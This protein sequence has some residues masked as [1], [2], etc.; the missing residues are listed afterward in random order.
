V[1][2]DRLDVEMI[3]QRLNT[4]NQKAQEPLE[5]HT[6]SATNAAQGNPFHQQAFDERTGVIRD[7]VLFEAVDKLTAAVVAVIVLFAVM[8]MAVFLVLGR[9]TPWTHISD[10]HRLLLTSAGVENVFGQQ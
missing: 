9:L 5:S 4:V 8:N 2:G 10:D 1:A 3:R 7:A 6:D